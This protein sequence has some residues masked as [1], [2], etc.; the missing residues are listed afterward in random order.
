MEWLMELFGRRRTS[1]PD[2][3]AIRDQMARDDPDYARVREV[4][5]DALS[6]LA[7]RR[8]ATQI[9]DRWNERLRDSWR[10]IS[11]P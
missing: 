11:D 3:A 8:G 5:H 4:Q 2:P 9:R 7:A 1:R 10:P 6:A